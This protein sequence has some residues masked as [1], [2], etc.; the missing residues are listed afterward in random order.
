MKY[1][2]LIISK[3]ISTM[4]FFS[5]SKVIKKNIYFLVKVKTG[6]LAPRVK[7]SPMERET[8]VQSQVDSYQRHFLN[9]L[10]T[11]LLNTQ[12][13][14]VRIKGKVKQFWERSRALPYALM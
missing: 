6:S 8:G 11:S 12:H 4:K 14:K 7:C 9:V 1:T 3:H 10:D 5:L 13:Y 2:I